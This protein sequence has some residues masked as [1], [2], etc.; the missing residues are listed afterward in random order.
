[1]NDKH[2]LAKT[3]DHLVRQAEAHPGEPKRQPLTRGLRV[4]VL[5]R[6]GR[7]FLQISRED[8]W[9]STAEWQTVTRLFPRPVPNI[10]PR[11]IHDSGTYRYFLKADW[12]TI[13]VEQAELQGMKAEE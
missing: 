5:V 12:A 4:D 2:G 7:T 6:D 8:K 13:V 11:R 9:P 3:L 10:L 1:M